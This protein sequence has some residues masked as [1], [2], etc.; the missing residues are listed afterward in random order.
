M[1]E[2][3]SS[4]KVV[5]IDP[6]TVVRLFHQLYYNS[7]EQTWFNTTWMGFPLLKCPLD[8]WIYQEMIVEIQPDII[9]ETGTHKGGSALYLAFLMDLL[10]NNGQVLSIDIESWPELPSHPLIT[11][12]NGS[13]TEETIVSQVRE[14][15]ADKK[16][17]MVILDS[18]H[19]CD[20]VFKEMEIYGAMVSSGSYMIV[21]DSNVNGHPVKPEH[22]PGPMEAIN[23]Y[24]QKHSDF[25][26]DHSREKFFMTQNPNGFLRKK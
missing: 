4:N 7:A 21:E 25:E 20:H 19:S 10:G 3:D 12:L 17:V 26:I 5:N 13:S 16:K 2:L 11:Y 23:L 9:V 22:G 8:L 15:I 1:S 6:Q 14:A 24:L 18:D